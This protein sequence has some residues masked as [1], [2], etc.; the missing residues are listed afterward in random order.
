LD[1]NSHPVPDGTLV[2]FRITYG[3]G[4][5]PKLVEG[6]TLKGI[7]K[8]SIRVE[9]AGMLW[10]EAESEGAKSQRLEFEI[11][12]EEG[13]VVLPTPTNMPTMTPTPTPTVTLSPTFVPT[14]TPEPPRERTNLTEWFLA[15]FITSG[16]GAAIYWTSSIMGQVRWGVRGGFLALIGGLLAYSYLAAGLPGSDAL[17]Q[18]A[19]TT[20]VALIILLGVGIGWSAS[21]GWRSLQKKRI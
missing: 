9:Q 21:L 2:R 15:L 10:I 5:I 18:R 17:V 7:A 16:L 12:S 19:G 13:E 4:G 11:L 14:P 6:T 1:Y 8:T 3:E 20:G